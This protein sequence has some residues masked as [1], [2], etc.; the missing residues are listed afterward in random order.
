MSYCVASKPLEVDDFFLY[1]AMKG[2]HVNRTISSFFFFFFKHK[3]AFLSCSVWVNAVTTV[4]FC[5]RRLWNE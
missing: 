2:F 4:V 1:C 5:C 3:L